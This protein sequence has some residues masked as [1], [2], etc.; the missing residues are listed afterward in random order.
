[1]MPPSAA[2]SMNAGGIH[3]PQ[4]QGKLQPQSC[5]M[6]LSEQ[7]AERGLYAWFQSLASGISE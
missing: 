2:T 5:E 3:A 4:H 1:M 7:L 6:S